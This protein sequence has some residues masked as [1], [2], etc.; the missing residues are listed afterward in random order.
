M[1]PVKTTEIYESETKNIA[2]LHPMSAIKPHISEQ[3]DGN[4]W[5]IEIDEISNTLVAEIRNSA[6]K[7]VSFASISL[8][9]GHV[10]F[11]NFSMPERWLTG[12]ETAFNGVMLLHNYQSEA[13]PAHKGLVAIDVTSGEM[14]W[15][16]YTLAF[17]HL[18]VEGPIVYDVHIHPRKLFLADIKT[19]ATKR[20]FEPSVYQ[21]LKNNIVIPDLKSSEWLATGALPVHPYGESIHCLDYTHFR[22]VSLH[23]LKGGVLMQLIFIMDGS[24]IVYQDMLNTG[25]QK[26]QPESFIMHNNRLIY[27]KNKSELLVLA[28]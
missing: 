17:D 15:S 22:I 8:A 21:E 20:I 9:D 28:L 16:N 5:R 18:S 4:I 1:P 24:H 23:A 10:Y 14:L 19:G 13:S 2:Y 3:F 11:K 6:D 7:Q 27:I 25:I 26:F 12:I